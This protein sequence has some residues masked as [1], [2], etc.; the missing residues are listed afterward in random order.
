MAESLMSQAQADRTGSAK[1]FEPP[2]VET[3]TPPELRD[4][5]DRVV[6]AGMRVLYGGDMQEEVKAELAR[7]VPMAQK[8]AE[9]VVGLLLTL[10]QKAPQ[11]IPEKVL[12]PASQALLGEAVRLASAAGQTVT[13][14]DFSEASMLVFQGIGRKL[15]Y[16]DEQMMQA[17]SGHA[18]PDTDELPDGSEPA[19][20]MPEDMED[21]ETRQ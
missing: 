11:G 5:V 12:A 17:V 15:G 19:G 18:E 13:K 14:D 20:G 4:G 10:D 2:A 16:S 21:E 1:G 9:A 8:L 3:F 6:A 7:D